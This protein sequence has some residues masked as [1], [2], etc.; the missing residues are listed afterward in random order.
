LNALIKL[1]QIEEKSDDPSALN[2]IRQLLQP[3]EYT[4]IDKIIK[5]SELS[6]VR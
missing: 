4:K 5:P 6:D 2:Q 1:V 3:F